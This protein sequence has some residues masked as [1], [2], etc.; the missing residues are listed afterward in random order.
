MGAR[1]D[2]IPLDLIFDIS[3]QYPLS[4]KFF[5]FT[6]LPVTKLPALSVKG[7]TP[8]LMPYLLLMHL[9]IVLESLL[10]MTTVKAL[11]WGK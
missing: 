6:Y 2:Y 8:F 10:Q 11:V 7:P 4:T 1:L 5:V 9:K 3:V